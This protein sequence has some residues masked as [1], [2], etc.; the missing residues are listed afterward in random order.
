[1]S[2]LHADRGIEDVAMSIEMVAAVARGKPVVAGNHEW[3]D[4]PLEVIAHNG[5][6][7]AERHG[8][9]WLELDA[10]D[11]AGVRF[12]GA[13]LW[14]PGESRYFASVV[15]LKHAAADVVVTHFEPTPAIIL[16]GLKEGGVWIYGHHHGHYDRM[17][18]G[19]RMGRGRGGEAVNNEYRHPPSIAEPPKAS[20]CRAD[21]S[22]WYEVELQPAANAER[23]P[24]DIWNEVVAEENT[25]D[26]TGEIIRFVV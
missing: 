7:A 20:R 4:A 19:R 16:S 14:T 15:F 12:A 5:Q 18:A 1:L 9:H 21:G 23:T 11:I 2:D 10:V 13:T 8:I 22:W 6:R 3:G 24:E 26:E 25:A 17:I